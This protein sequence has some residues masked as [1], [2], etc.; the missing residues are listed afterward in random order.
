MLHFDSFS[1]HLLNCGCWKLQPL[2][3]KIFD[4]N[5]QWKGSCTAMGSRGKK[6]TWKVKTDSESRLDYLC[7]GGGGDFVFGNTHDDQRIHADIQVGKEHDVWM[8][9]P[10]LSIPLR[11]T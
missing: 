2:L 6:T 9:P 4:K 11:S 1:D 3:A 5:Q 7:I 8:P 10:F